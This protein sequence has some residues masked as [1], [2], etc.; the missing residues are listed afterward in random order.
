MKLLGDFLKVYRVHS[1]KS[2]EKN[3]TVS[4]AGDVMKVFNYNT[5]PHLIVLMVGCLEKLL[6]YIGE[7]QQI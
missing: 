1:T 7:I 5:F 3:M 6:K 2:I 4:H